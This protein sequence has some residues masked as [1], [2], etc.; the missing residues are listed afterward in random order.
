MIAPADHLAPP[1]CA[2]PQTFR[3]SLSPGL[4]RLTV[5]GDARDFNWD[6]LFLTLNIF[7]NVNQRTGPWDFNLLANHRPLLPA[8][9]VHLNGRRIGLWYFNRPSKAQLE[10]RRLKGEASF[11]I[12]EPGDYEFRFEP[13]HAFH[14]EW[15]NTRFETETDDHLLDRLSLRPSAQ[16]GLQRLFPAERWQQLAQW[17]EDPEFPYRAMLK[18]SLAWAKAQA[19]QADAPK[20][21]TSKGGYRSLVLPLLAAAVRLHGDQE[22]LRLART[23]TEGFL[24]QPAWGNPCEDGYGHNGDIGGAITM[25]DLA[26]TLNFLGDDLG[27]SL[28][29]RL[30]ARLEVQGDRFLELGLLHRGYWGGSILQDHGFCSF[31][32][33]TTAA[34]SLFGWTPRANCWLRFCLP[35]MQRTLNALPTDGVI[36]QSSYHELF[37]YTDKVVLFRELHRQATGADIY[38]QPAWRNV[39]HFAYVSYVTEQQR[40]L[41]ASTRADLVQFYGGHAFLDQI[42]RTFHDPEAAW[43]AREYVRTATSAGHYHPFQHVQAMFQATL[44]AALLYEPVEL[45]APNPPPRRLEWF[46]DTG[47]V[48]YRDDARGLILSA[49]C[50]PPNGLTAHNHTTCSCDRHTLSPSAGLFAIVKRGRLLLQNAERG[51][52]TH[53]ALANVMLVDGRGQL[54]D[55]APPMSC[56]DAPYGGEHIEQAALASE[57]GTGYVR[58]QITPAYDADLGLTRY[59]REFFCECGGTIRLVDSVTSAFPH[60]FTWLFHA[61]KSH[62]II[63]QGPLTFRIQNHPEQLVL[64]VRQTTAPLAARIEDTLVVWAQ[65]NQ[66]ND[67]TFQHIEFTTTEPVREISV[68]FALI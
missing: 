46:R 33:L 52:K 4:Y 44:W 31:S 50:G 13:Y 55:Y 35:R 24:A 59:T 26:W 66:H 65:F 53:T 61:Y 8:Y 19:R 39:P 28:A 15:A 58:M 45:P 62:P 36:P 27:K 11:W 30:L 9:W 67:E 42:A 48:L 56:P 60:R 54:G 6:S 14:L 32:F 20:G 29:Q 18:A 38:E 63:S 5:D 12:T 16:H 21:P 3:R 41:H 51:Y 25:L 49:R 7:R 68:E 57:T 17:L 2:R 23:I 34:Y 64:T 22:A 1:S 47:A 40:F 43:L 37:L 10:A